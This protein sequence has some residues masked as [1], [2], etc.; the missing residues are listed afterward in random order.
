[1]KTAPFKPGT[2][3]AG[4]NF[5]RL[6]EAAFVS[7][8]AGN[9]A[10]L[11]SSGLASLLSGRVGPALSSRLARAG[12]M[13]EQ[14]D[15]EAMGSALR[16]RFLSG[17][18]GPHVHILTLTGHC[19]LSCAYCSAASDSRS[20][21][22]HM[23]PATVRRA[24]DFIFSIDVPRLVL[25]FQGGE[26]LLN[27][28]ALTAAVDAASARASRE[29]RAV[30]F[31]IVTNLSSMN[32][33]K[34]RFLM[35]RRV[36]VCTSLDGPHDLHDANRGRGAHAA[37]VKWL[38]R[39]NDYRKKHPEAEAP[40]AICTVTRAALSRPEEIVDEFVANGI[41]RVQLGPLDPLGRARISWDKLGYAPGEFVEFYGR[42]LDRMEELTLKTGR[43]VYEKGALGF[44]R[45]TGSGR[46][47]QS[48]N[49][50]V[51]FRL[52]YNWDGG[53]YGSDEARMLAGGGDELF[54]LGTVGRD[55]FSAVL[56]RPLAKALLLSC[57]PEL[58]QPSCSRCAFS[59]YCRVSPAHN[60]AAQNSFWG[61]MASSQR[62][63]IFKGVFR[64]LAEGWR[65]PKRRRVFEKWLAE[66]V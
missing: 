44:L 41:T 18:R 16:S 38:G 31:S 14:L 19:G 1:M 45:E 29:G 65:R 55:T 42:A 8:L 32:E 33:E 21:Q 4:F 37:A 58:V 13:R 47:P 11:S 24:L 35:K 48:R 3:P 20:N 49:L 22:G 59:P 30:H 51:A 15:M 12:F 61:D 63:A 34:F 53:I 9:C 25:E 64:L 54:R 5:E 50:D 52:A 46:R 66:G 40:N 26:P 43:A 10:L 23:T 6:Q 57:F 39:I 2:V 28:G 36:T 17:W 62:C 7:G 27:F 60:F 56:G